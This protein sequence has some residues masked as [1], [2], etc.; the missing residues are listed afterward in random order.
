ME[1]GYTDKPDGRI[2]RFIRRHHVMTVATCSEGPWCANLF[3]AWLD[4]PGCFVFTSDGDTR[5][6][7]DFVR[8]GEAAASVVLETRTVGRVQGLQI[9]GTVVRAAGP[10]QKTASA[11]LKAY[12]KRFPYAAAAKLELWLLLPHVLKYTDNTLGFGKKI[13]WQAS[14]KPSAY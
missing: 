11:A 12:L 13:L 4:E 5:H 14:G 7:T 3:Y 10:G 2:I 1:H 9:T 6:G 8:C